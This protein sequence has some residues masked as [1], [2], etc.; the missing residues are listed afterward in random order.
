LITPI[1]RADHRRSFVRSLLL[2]CVAIVAVSGAGALI[3]LLVF[4][5]HQDVVLKAAFVAG[6]LLIALTL[7]NRFASYLYD[8]GEEPTPAR[9]TRGS[10][11]E[12]PAELLEIEARVS[13]AKVSEFDHRTRLRPLLREL[14][15]QRLDASRNVDTK[16]QPDE[17]RHVL[18]PDLW[19]EVQSAPTSKDLRDSPGPTNAAIIRLVEKIESL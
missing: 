10:A 16:R 9:S 6:A 2:R 4:G 18:G 7:L 19:D 5:G 12:W 8:D 11:P 3:A 13:L 14:A 17:A 15:M 1:G